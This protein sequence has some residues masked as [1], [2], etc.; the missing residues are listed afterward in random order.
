MRL[1][2]D[3]QRCSRCQGGDLCSLEAVVYGNS[4][5]PRKSGNGGIGAPCERFAMSKNESGSLTTPDLVLLSLLAERPMH[6]YQVN[7]ELERRQIRDWAGVSRPQVYYSI[8]KLT[9]LQML[10]AADSDGPA[11]GPDRRAFASN[12]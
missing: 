8:E 5:F 6:G 10:M 11:A 3:N 4:C 9:R 2:E 1:E 12:A 7:A